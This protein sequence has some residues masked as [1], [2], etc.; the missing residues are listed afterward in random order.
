[1]TVETAISFSRW[2][3][4][5]IDGDDCTWTDDLH[6]SESGTITVLIVQL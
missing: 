5:A 3:K 2:R 1:M 4:V 6:E